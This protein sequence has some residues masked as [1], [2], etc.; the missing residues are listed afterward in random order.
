MGNIYTD[1]AKPNN[2]QVEDKMDANYICIQSK[3]NQV[4][5]I[6]WQQMV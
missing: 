1:L 3:A 4:P 2:T 6:T 5:P